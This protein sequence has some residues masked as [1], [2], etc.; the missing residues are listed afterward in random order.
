MRVLICGSMQWHDRPRIR[1]VLN[2]LIREAREAGEEFVVIH[3][4][5]PNGA[6]KIAD[7]ICWSE[8]GMIPGETLI[9]EP[10]QYKRYQRVAGNVR[11]QTML[12]KHKPTLVYAFRDGIKSK[13]TDDM[14]R[15]ARRAGVPTRVVTPERVD[16]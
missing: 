6:E 12:D 13:E 7:E 4:A 3:G 10:A 14:V 2:R 16:A 8:L 9:R 5:H 1:A 11:N 15:R